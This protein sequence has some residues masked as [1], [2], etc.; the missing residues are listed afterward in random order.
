MRSGVVYGHADLVAGLLARFD[1]EMGI[2][3]PSRMPVVATG[4]LAPVIAPLVDRIDCVV[5]DLTLDGLRIV[6]QMNGALQ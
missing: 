1:E 6:A 4:G 5:P 2:D 3:D